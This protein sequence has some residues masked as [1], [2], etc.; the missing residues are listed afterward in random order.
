MQMVAEHIC[1]LGL[2]CRISSLLPVDEAHDLPLLRHV[3]HHRHLLHG[4][5]SCR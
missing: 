4:D 2:R 1:N 5:E 3:P